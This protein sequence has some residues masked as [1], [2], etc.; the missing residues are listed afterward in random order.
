MVQDCDVYIGRQISR[1]GWNLPQSK[2]HNPFTRR[3]S[4]PT[5][6]LVEKYRKYVEADEELMG[7]LHELKGK[8]LGCWCKPKPCHGDVLVELVKKHC[9]E[10]KRKE[11]DSPN[12]SKYFKKQK[13]E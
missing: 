2:W 10:E 1:G 12:I 4:G 5:E 8:T 11:P 7:A 3:N 13:T 9:G 6:S